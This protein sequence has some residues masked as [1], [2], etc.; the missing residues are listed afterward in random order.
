MP[1]PSEI[2]LVFTRSSLHLITYTNTPQV[3]IGEKAIFAR[4]KRMKPAS[5][6]R[7][8]PQVM[9]KAD[10]K[11]YLHT[12]LLTQNLGLVIGRRHRLAN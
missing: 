8:T 1:R 2:M 4:D 7:L 3:T 10:G 9:G 5:P 12:C 11:W 6:F